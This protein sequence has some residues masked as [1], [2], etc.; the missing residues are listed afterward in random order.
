MMPYFYAYSENRDFTFTPSLF[1]NDIQMFQTEYREVGKKYKLI[2]DFGFTKGYKSSYSNKKKNINHFFAEY[3]LNLDLDNFLSS[4]FSLSSERVSNDTYLKIFDANIS[5][6]KVKPSNFDVL[7]SE[8]KLFLDHENY[9][10][11]TGFQA[12][13]DL[14][15][16]SSDKYQYV[17]PYFDF[18]KQLSQN[19][20]RGSLNLSSYGTN[21]L[22]KY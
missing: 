9:D 8:I 21:E 19:F 11:E 18:N 1:E 14:S 4:K 20:T 3:N 16:Q 17:L 15:L 7:S 10:F 13:E 6:S 2:A 5:N 22:K 12:F